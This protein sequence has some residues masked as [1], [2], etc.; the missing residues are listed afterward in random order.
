MN[1]VKRTKITVIFTTELIKLTRSKATQSLRCAE[2]FV[3][4]TLSGHE[5]I[6]IAAQPNLRWW[7]MDG[8]FFVDIS[9]VP[10]L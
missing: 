10:K 8:T 1:S 6:S 2:C 3:N 4:N 9:A 7:W 5:E